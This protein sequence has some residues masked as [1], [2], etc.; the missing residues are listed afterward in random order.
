MTSKRL[1]APWRAPYV[2]SIHK[3]TT[4]CVFCKII[5]SRKDKKNYIFKRT[6]HCFAVLNIFPYNNGHV[7]VIPNRHVSDLKNLR[8][9]EKEDLFQLL[10]DAKDLLGI[11]LKPEGYNIGINIGRV[12]GAGF[13]GHFHI[14]IVPRWKGD[15]NFMPVTTNAKVISQSMVVLHEKLVNANKTRN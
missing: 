15:V 6:K 3:K 5:K 9:E 10:E 12:A 13:P 8:K 2:T 1:W 11:V 7:L 4:G 14:H